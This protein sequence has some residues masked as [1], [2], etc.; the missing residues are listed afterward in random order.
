[1]DYIAVIGYYIIKDFET[2]SLLFNILEII[3]PVYLG[4]Y[5]CKKLVEVID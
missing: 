3:E 1:M 5:L 2:H 4:A